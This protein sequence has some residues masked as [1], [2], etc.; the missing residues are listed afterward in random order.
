[1]AIYKPLNINISYNIVVKVQKDLK[2]NINILSNMHPWSS[3]LNQTKS[4][5]TL[6]AP[7]WLINTTSKQH[8]L[9]T[10]RKGRDGGEPIHKKYKANKSMRTHTIKK[11][12]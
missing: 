1:M 10:K 3:S 4:K 2:S 11:K 5:I 6:D 12:T 8:A 7:T 9:I